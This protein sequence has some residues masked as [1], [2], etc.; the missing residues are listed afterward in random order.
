HRGPEVVA[1]HVDD[2]PVLELD[3][4]PEI[5]AG[6]GPEVVDELIRDQGPVEAPA[7]ANVGEL[8]RVEMR[9]PEEPFG[10]A[11]AGPDKEKEQDHDRDDGHDGLGDL[12]QQ[13][14]RAHDG[15]RSVGRASGRPMAARHSRGSRRL[16]SSSAAPPRRRLAKTRPA[17]TTTT[18]TRPT[19]ISVVFE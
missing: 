4:D 18:T 1:D 5:A 13:I 16:H 14:P 9:V 11:G 19:M 7:S 12:S 8:G 6:G 2:R 3:R 10:G 15:R 17:T